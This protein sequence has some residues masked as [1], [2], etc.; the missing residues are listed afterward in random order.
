MVLATRLAVIADQVDEV[1]E[2]E[3]APLEMVPDL[4]ARWPTAKR[5]L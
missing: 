4:G 1:F 5:L 2:I 3:D